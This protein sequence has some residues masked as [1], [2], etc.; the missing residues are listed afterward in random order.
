MRVQ[1]G[2]LSACSQ[3]AHSKARRFY[4]KKGTEMTMR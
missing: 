2:E 1:S 4:I 3:F